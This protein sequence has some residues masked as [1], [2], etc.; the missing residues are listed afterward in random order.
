M[1]FFAGLFSALL[2][3]RSHLSSTQMRMRWRRFGWAWLLVGSFSLRADPDGSVSALKQLSM[4]ELMN[5]EVTSVSRHAE[6]LLDAASAIQVITGDD[7]RRSGALTIPEALRLADNLDVAQ[8]NSHDWG[9][10]ARGFNTELANKLLVMIDGRTVY[11]PLFSGVI[12]NAQDYLLED[13]DRIEV[14]SGPGGTLW[15]AN[16]VNGVINI[17]TKSA[18]ATQGFYAEGGAGSELPGFAGARYGGTLAPNVYFRVYGKYIDQGNSRYPSGAGATDDWHRGQGGFR[19]DGQAPADNAFTVQGDLYRERDGALAGGQNEIR[20]GNLLGRWVKTFS[21]ESELTLQAYYDRTR[22]TQPAPAFVLGG[23]TLAPAG[24][25]SDDLTTYDLD[26]QHRFPLG[27]TNRVVWGL[28]YR[29]T[30]DLAGNAPSLAFLPA[31][32]DQELWSGFVQDEWR[33]SPTVALTVGTK[34]EHNDYTGREVEPSAQLQ[35]KPVAAQMAWASISRAVRTPSR[36]DRDVSQAAPP[37]LAVLKGSPAFES[38]VVVAY[39]AGYRAQVGA[40][41]V[42]SVAAFYND[43]DKVRSTNFTPVTLLPFYFANDLEGETHGLELTGDMQLRPGWRLHLGYRWLKEDL[44]VKPGAYDLNNALNETSD[45]PQQVTLRTAVDLPGAVELDASLRWVDDRPTHNGAVVGELP[46]YAE[47]DV[48]MGWRP[49]PEL[50]LALV[51][52]NL[53]HDRHPEYGF[54][55][56]TRPEIPRRIYGKVSWRY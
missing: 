54:A 38:E 12:W 33:F 37:Y 43:Y 52:Q 31:A 41:A 28:G 53:L 49:T 10:S 20:G 24:M 19:I 6:K 11:T 46:A 13:L 14:L 17:S 55:G 36:I 40:S 50:E 32:L 9:I 23:T 48:H 22:L 5:I 56:A 51:G 34:L 4:E 2:A 1:I 7:I 8:K 15:G 35:W 21:A 26:F 45:P 44:R 16:A 42:V 30:E 25:F 3:A 27:D 18:K 47:L 39:E 29:R